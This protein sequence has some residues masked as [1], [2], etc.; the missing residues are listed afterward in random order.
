MID[1]I[2]IDG[3]VYPITK[4]RPGRATGSDHLSRWSSRRLVGNTGIWNKKQSEYKKRRR[5]EKTKEADH[6]YK[7][8]KRS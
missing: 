4:C 8:Q 7:E 1:Y 5:K 6:F 3:E 2:T